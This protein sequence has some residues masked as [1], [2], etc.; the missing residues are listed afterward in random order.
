MA[1]VPLVVV[2]ACFTPRNAANSVSNFS[3]Y[4]PAELIQ[5][6]SMASATYCFASLVRMGSLTGTLRG[7]VM[8]QHGKSWLPCHPGTALVS[9]LS[10]GSVPTHLSRVLLGEKAKNHLSPIPARQAYST[11]RRRPSLLSFPF[12]CT[13]IH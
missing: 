13:K 7:E 10:C 2:T 4:F 8:R 9:L 3:M 1:V 6:D 12:L 5:P 11:L